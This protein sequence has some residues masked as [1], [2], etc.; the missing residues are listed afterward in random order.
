[1]SAEECGAREGERMDQVEFDHRCVSRFQFSILDA[2]GM[3]F[4]CN[5]PALCGPH[6]TEFLSSPLHA[7]QY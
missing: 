4:I 3:G 2:T 5:K 1:M 6:H 7:V